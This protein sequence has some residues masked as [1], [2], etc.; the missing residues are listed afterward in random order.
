MISRSEID[1][2][3]AELDLRMTEGDPINIRFWVRDAEEWSLA[4]F[5]CAIRQHPGTEN[6][7]LAAPVV[8]V[9]VA[10]GPNPE[11]GTG[12]NVDLVTAADPDL[13]AANSPY[14]WGM[15]ETGGVTRFG[16]MFYVEPRV[17]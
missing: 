6:P 8:T 7:I 12:L 13:I 5:T 10:N 14:V 2:S 17:V 1:Q 15:K 3:H 16:G 11:D 9:A 4:S